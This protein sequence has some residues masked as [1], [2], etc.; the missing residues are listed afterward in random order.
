VIRVFSGRS[1]DGIVVVA[2]GYHRGVRAG[3]ICSADIQ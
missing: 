1:A 3:F 2:R